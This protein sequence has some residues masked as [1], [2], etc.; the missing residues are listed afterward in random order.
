[1]KPLMEEVP[2]GPEG[3]ASSTVAGLRWSY[4]STAASMIT[5]IAYTATMSRLLSPA[6]FGV[7]AL[8]G[9]LL[10]FVTYFGQLGIGSAIV[11][12]PTLDADDRRTAFTVSVLTAGTVAVGVAVLAPVAGRLFHLESLPG[13]LR[14][15]AVA[16]FVTSLGATSAA[17][18]RRRMRFRAVAASEFGSFAIGYLGVG[19]AMASAGAGVWSLVGASVTQSVVLTCAT[20]A[21]APHSLAPSLDRQR[22]RSLVRFGGMVSVVGFTE[23]LTVSLDSVSV[24]LVL[25]ARD[26][27]FYNR[28]NLLVGLPVENFSTSATKVLLPSFSSMQSSPARVAKAYE[29]GIAFFVAT[30]AP[31][32]GAIAATSPALV[33]VL[34]GDQWHSV[35]A[36]VPFVALAAGV[37]LIT[38]FAGVVCEAMALLREKLKIQLIQLIVLSVILVIVAAT[39]GDLRWFAGAWAAGELVRH[40]LYLRLVQRELRPSYQRVRNAYV[41]GG[42]LTTVP[43][44]A[45]L[46]VARAVPGPPVAVLVAQAAAGLLAYT[47][48]LVACR[49]FEVRIQLRERNLVAALTGSGRGRPPR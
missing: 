40:G 10:R 22:V 35:A 25:G 1:M 21:L 18:L 46:L 27:G 23:F 33:R 5:Q 7:V 11:Q 30:V 12:K 43:V 4:S 9:L 19:L 2:A 8:G 20:F 14:G 36:V 6:A 29:A 37:A 32:C 49:G 44:L 16:F 39:T 38:H 15:L 24:G 45:M 28:A 48:L 47:G 26:L 42:L 17:T 41:Q 3:L 34:L 13:V 31:L